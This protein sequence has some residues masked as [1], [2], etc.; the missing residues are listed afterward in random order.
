MRLEYR[1]TVFTSAF[2]IVSSFALCAASVVAAAPAHAQTDGA[3]D[4]P[5]EAPAD[6][7]PPADDNEIVVTAER[8][9]GSVETEQAP[10][11]E[12]DEAEIASYGANSIAD[13]VGQLSAQTGSGRGRGGGRP[14]FLINGQRISSFREFRRYPP[15]AIKTVQVLPEEVAL[16]YGFSPDQRVLNFILKDNFASRE[17]E[18]GLSTPTAGGRLS[19][20]VEA[21][22]LTIDGPRR[23]NIAAEYNG[24]SLLTENERDIIQTAGSVSDVATDPDPAPFRSLAS[25]SDN[26]ELDATYSIGLG[27]GAGGQLTLSAGLDRTETTSLSGLDT[28]ILRDA[29]GNG[30]IRV[31]DD[32]PLER[33]SESTTYT[34]GSALN[35][36][37]G[38]W[39][40]AATFNASRTDGQTEIDRRRPGNTLQDAVDA[41][42]L[43]PDGVLPTVPDAG[44]DTARSQADAISTKLTARGRPLFLPAGELRTNFDAGYS[45]TSIESVDTR[46]GGPPTDL[47]RGDLSGGVSLVAP[48]TSRRE[49]VLAGLGDLTLSLGAGINELSDFGTLTDYNIGLTW[50]PV[51]KLTLSATRIVAEAAPG[52][53]VLGSPVVETFN[54]PVFDFATGANTL[55]TIITGGNPDLRAET[56]KDW[57]LGATLQLDWFDR[58]SLSVEYFANSSRDTVEGFPLLTP[59]IEAAFPDRVTRDDLTGRLLAVDR[60]SVTFARR[61]S[62]RLRFGVNLFGR[63]DDSG[64]GG[65]R[66]PGGGRPGGA[67]GGQAD[68]DGQTT[69]SESNSSQ[70]AP[71]TAR[72]T[73][74]PRDDGADGARA[75]NRR[76][77]MPF[78]PDRFAALRQQVCAMEPAALAAK[79]NRDNTEAGSGGNGASDGEAV[80]RLPPQMLE[81]LRGDNGQVDPERVG[82]L[83]ARLCSDEASARMARRMEGRSPQPPATGSDAAK[84]ADG[85][86]KTEQQSSEQKG[87]QVGQSRSQRRGGGGGMRRGGPGRWNA[88]VYYSLELRNDA[89]V[90]D[91]GP[92][93]DLL[94]GD[95]LGGGGVAKHTVQFNGGFFTDGIG[96]RL[97]ANYDSGY[98]V[99]ELTFDGLASVS[100]RAFI[101]LSQ[102][103]WLTG[104][105]PGIFKGTRVSFSV[106]N[107]FDSRRKVT[108]GDGLVP[109]AYQPDLI[110]PVGRVVS[111]D[112]RKMF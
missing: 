45:Y 11:I 66:P 73:A 39:D 83:Q 63:I 15:E 22:L 18:L 52:L 74:S 104:P 57:K 109:L 61:D 78:D 50:Q 32:N 3:P 47:S 69:G 68:T 89:L 107:I 30:T 93:L 46:F 34:L 92:R 94:D 31:L 70:S 7:G 49:D 86:A 54:V 36:R 111:F 99:D 82:R 81:R 60:R 75:G 38:F 97:N 26:G 13:L 84:P 20:E 12:L 23:M 24:S 91:A 43:A 59:T 67:R 80:L 62:E 58:T 88:S 33:R 9:F 56:Q 27:G 6:P 96:V 90:A 41:G 40:M 98:E 112:L 85:H 95:A 110:D 2:G 108:D 48:L 44:F 106:S 25:R 21:S 65:G 37:L 17:L 5:A 105:E 16:E 51:D 77:G 29:A 14:I 64:S 71:T 4:V 76:G 72:P 42:A 87:Q 101:D 102:Q 103:T 79:L 28:V 53:S 10:I 100:A 35:K 1:P 8:F 19:S 55:A